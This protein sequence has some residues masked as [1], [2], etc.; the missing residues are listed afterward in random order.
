MA[1]ASPPTAIADLRRL[2]ERAET[3]AGA[4]EVLPFGVAA[5]DNCLPGGGLA[6][7]ALHEVIDGGSAETCAAV[8][9]Q[10]R[11]EKLCWESAKTG[12]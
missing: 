9:A 1:R 3:P 2:L 8:T 5:I 11:L 12:A 4:R 7:G 10:E 6:Q